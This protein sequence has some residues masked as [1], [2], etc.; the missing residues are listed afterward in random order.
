LAATRAADGRTLDGFRC[1]LA[2][3][4]TYVTGDEG[5]RETWV[6]ALAAMLNRPAAPLAGQVLVGP[7]EECARRL[8]AYA[9]AGIDQVFIWPL[10]HAERQLDLFMREV[11]PLVGRRPAG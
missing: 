3:M 8:T 4:W 11:A 9:E 5:V 10:A 6:A 1:A 7:A 2:T